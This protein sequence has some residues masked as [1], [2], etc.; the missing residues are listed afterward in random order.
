[1]KTTGTGVACAVLL[2]GVLV[3]GLAALAAGSPWPTG[4]EYRFWFSGA[5]FSG[6]ASRAFDDAPTA[7]SSGARTQVFWDGSSTAG[8][9]PG[10]ARLTFS[11][12]GLPAGGSSGGLAGVGMMLVLLDFDLPSGAAFLP[13]TAR[14]TFTSD[15]GGTPIV[16]GPTV[17]GSGALFYYQPGTGYTF[18]AR[19]ASVFASGVLTADHTTYEIVVDNVP[20]PVTIGLFAAGGIGLLGRLVLKRRRS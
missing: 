16:V 18:N 4:E 15:L 19:G 9:D 10:Q 2:V 11:L 14:M 5:F 17:F 1:M 6:N 20:E 13:D 7:F 8:L 3:L 12:D